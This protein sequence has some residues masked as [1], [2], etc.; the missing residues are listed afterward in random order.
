MNAIYMVVK[1]FC[2]KEQAEAFAV[3]QRALGRTAIAIERNGE[4]VVIEE[5]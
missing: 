5:H 4:Y 2:D 3:A 1:H